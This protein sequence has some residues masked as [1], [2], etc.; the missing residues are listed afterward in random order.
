M[1]EN[2]PKN[3]RNLIRPWSN[4]DVFN[5]TIL[6][7]KTEFIIDRFAPKEASD[8][9]RMWV[10]ERAYSGGYR[11]YTPEFPM[12]Y[13]YAPLVDFVMK[14][15]DKRGGDLSKWE[16]YRNWLVAHL[17]PVDIVAALWA[18]SPELLDKYQNYVD[19]YK[20][21]EKTREGWQALHREFKEILEPYGGVMLLTGG[22]VV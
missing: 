10:E 14:N 17:D 8:I 11:K 19:R 21:M 20:G 22:D 3:P 6:T 5:D 9:A 16:Y 7:H 15:A 18:L 12:F 2:I 13:E 1:S 4:A